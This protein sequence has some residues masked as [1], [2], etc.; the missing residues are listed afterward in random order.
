MASPL[1]VGGD[2][3]HEDMANPNLNTGSPVAKFMLPIH[4]DVTAGRRW[5]DEPFS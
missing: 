3:R 4:D 5:H 1:P 2:R